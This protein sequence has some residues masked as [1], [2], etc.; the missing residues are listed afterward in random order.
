M[1]NNKKIT[2][3]YPDNVR[4]LIFVEDLITMINKI[5]KIKK[6]GILEVG[7]G[8]G[9]K[10]S[11]IA[12]AIQ[13]QFNFNCKIIYSKK[14]KSSKNFYSKANLK[15]NKSLINWYPKINLKKGLQKVYKL[16]KFYE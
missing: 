8:K 12:K 5:L 2:L 10:I 6:S 13:T 11:Q 15:K 4:D 9:T 7:T 3:R 14:R 16:N 1:R